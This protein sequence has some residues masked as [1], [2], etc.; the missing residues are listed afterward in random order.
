MTEKTKKHFVIHPAYPG[1]NKALQEFISQNMR[2]PEQAIKN[3]ITGSVHLQY[4]VTDE[5]IV[6]TVQVLKSLGYGC[7]EEAVRLVKLLKFG[8]VKNRGLRLK[9]TKKITINF[10]KTQVTQTIT[11]NIKQEENKST[12]INYTIKI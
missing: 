5:G 11:Y 6:E 7:D 3:N 12:T 9:S 1:G 8:S 2:Y 4:I 10:N